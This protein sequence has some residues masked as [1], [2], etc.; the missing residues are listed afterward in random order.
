MVTVGSRMPVVDTNLITAA[1]SKI[2]LQ[3]L[4]T[5]CGVTYQAIRKWERNG[6]LPYTDATGQT[7]YAGII[8]RE[9][10]G[11]LAKDQLLRWSF[12]GVKA[13]A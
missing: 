7:D 11:E 12:P 13:A 3:K 6:R 4:A 9:S 2:G 8:E 10:S 5:A 1:I